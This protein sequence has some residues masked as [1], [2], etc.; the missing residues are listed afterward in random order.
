MAIHDNNAPFSLLVKPAGPDCNL[1]CRYCFYIGHVGMFPESTRHRMEGATLEKLVRGYMALPF[2]THSFAWQG[3]EPTLAGVDF[4]R[5]AVALQRACAKP[6]GRIVNVLQT[7]AT[8]IDDEFANFLAEANFL[9]GVSIDGQPPLHDA[10]RVDADNRPTYKRVLDGIEALRRHNVAFNALVLVNKANVA[11][12]ESIYRHLRDDLKIYD[13]QYI[14]CADIDSNGAPL[15]FAIGGSE[16]G[17]F[18]CRIFDAWSKHDTRRVS[19]RLFDTVQSIAAGYGAPSCAAACECSGYFVIEH[20]GD[21]FPCDFHVT[22]SLRLG[23]IRDNSWKEIRSNPLR[24]AFAA[25]KGRMAAECQECKWLKF[26]Q[27]DC[28]RNRNPWETFADSGNATDA[29]S[30]L[31]DGWKRFYSHAA[32]KLVEMATAQLRGQARGTPSRND[33]CPCGSGLKYKHC[34]GRKN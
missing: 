34:C 28:P 16:W 13:H 14:E 10:S 30:R 26:C 5:R 8:L 3:G 18:L 21:V 19:V 9:V 7:N 25:R 29:R 11:A 20:N 2:E 15:P 32:G 33:P 23:N 12:P 1:R 6:G 27:G 22:P 31:C 4:F 24:A 17:E